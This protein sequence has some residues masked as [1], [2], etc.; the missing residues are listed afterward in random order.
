MSKTNILKLI[1]DMNEQMAALKRNVIEQGKEGLA[2][3]AKD[4]FNEVEGLKKFVILGYTPSFNDGEPCEHISVY[5]FGDYHWAEYYKHDGTYY[6]SSDDVGE[7][8]E[9]GEFF[10]FEGAGRYDETTSPHSFPIVYANS[11]VVDKKKAY[12]LIGAM[13][14][15]CEMLYDT[16]YVVYFTLNENG[17]VDV[18]QDDYDCGY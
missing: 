11:G 9:F 5:G 17:S 4:V 15:V 1:A 6:L 18:E 3:V 7:R 12:N 13:D 10:E 2:E 16:N 8:E 14:D